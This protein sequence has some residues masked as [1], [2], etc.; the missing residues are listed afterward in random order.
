MTPLYLVL[1]GLMLYSF[2]SKDW[3]LVSESIYEEA[4]EEARRNNHHA[5]ELRPLNGSSREVDEEEDHFE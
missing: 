1:D 5:L 4:E 2:M 3:L